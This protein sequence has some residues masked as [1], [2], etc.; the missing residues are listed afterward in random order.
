MK[1]NYKLKIINY[2]WMLAICFILS[3]LLWRGAGGEVFAQTFKM[4]ADTEFFYTY[5]GTNFDEARDI[6]ETADKGYILVGT[7]SSFGPGMASVYMIKTDSLGNHKWSGVQGGAENDHAYAVELTYDSGYFVSGYSNSFYA[8]NSFNYSAYY[9]KTDATGHLLWQKFIDNGAWSFI[10]GSCTV[11]DSGFILCG[12]TYATTYGDA[13][14]YL[15]RLNKNGDTLWTKHYGGT[16]TEVFN[17]VCIINNKIYAVGSNGSHAGAD[18][19]ADGWIVKT[20]MNGD[21]LQT[22]YVS[23]GAKQQETLNGI[24]KYNDSLFTVCGSNYH[25]D[26]SATTP[27]V[28]K[29]DT[30]LRINQDLTTMNGLAQDSTVRGYA[31]EFNKIVNI[32]YGNVCV[33]GSAIAGLGGYNMFF[34]GFSSGGWWI[35]DYLRHSGGTYNDYGYSGILTTGGKIIGVGSTQGFGGLPTPPYCTSP[36]MG[37]EDV[38]LVRFNSDSISNS[39]LTAQPLTS[40]P[41]VNCFADSLYLSQASI[42]NYTSNFNV[43]IFPNPANTM[44]NLTISPFDNV[45]KNNIEIYTIIG[46][47]V[48][49][50]IITSSNSQIDVSILSNGTYFLKI[51]DK[52]GQNVSVIKFIISR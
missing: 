24:T 47:C 26:S 46:E 50:Q 7:T 28:I 10:Y 17:S 31:V 5:G 43:N 9:F 15:I 48:H 27:I 6:K 25:I 52:K 18:S 21:T 41:Q 11:P 19:I 34:Q 23:Y 1:R 12:Q 29:Y 3:P 49:R 35:N 16:Q 38:Y 51:Q 13:D 22:K 36:K 2:K 37:L 32:S 14:G 44:T 45:H 4:A 20:D 40:S 33:I 8:N 42:K 39:V 30:S